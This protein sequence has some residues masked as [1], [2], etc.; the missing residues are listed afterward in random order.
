MVSRMVGLVGITKNM[1]RDS[2]F[3]SAFK[4]AHRLT[5]ELTWAR[6][7]WSR[8]EFP[9]W[10]GFTERWNQL[11]SHYQRALSDQQRAELE[12]LAGTGDRAAAVK[13][14]SRA[15]AS[16]ISVDM[17]LPAKFGAVEMEWAAALYISVCR[18]PPCRW[19]PV[20]PAEIGSFIRSTPL[21][22]FHFP[23][24]KPDF[25]LLCRQGYAVIWPEN[26]A[27]RLWLTPRGLRLCADALGV[28]HEGT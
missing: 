22:I 4:T 28:P 23:G 17:E 5:E 16:L 27:A 7:L 19:R 11:L 12:A 14:F 18:E 6:G 13:L 15:P 25:S 10:G 1:D 9:D 24:F 21:A 8:D 2:V 20:A 26:S 3:E